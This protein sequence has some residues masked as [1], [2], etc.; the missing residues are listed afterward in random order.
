VEFLLSP[1]QEHDAPHGRELLEIMGKQKRIIPLVMDRAYE[2]DYTRYIAQDLNF[3]PIVPPKRNRK[4]PWD[5]DKELYKT[6]NE[7]ERDF[8][9]IQGFRR[10]ATRYDKLDT[11]YSGFVQLAYVF[12]AIR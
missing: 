8:R 1:G 9:L 2:D 7:I 10:V 6:R 5:Y 3:K 12:M 4:N 11:M